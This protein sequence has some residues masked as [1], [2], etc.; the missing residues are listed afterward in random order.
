MQQYLAAL[1]RRRWL[2][3][4]SALLS[5]G[6]AFGLSQLQTPIYTSTA[7]VLV[8]SA[9]IST[10]QGDEAPNM[11]TESR[12]AKSD[13]VA[14]IVKRNLGL[15]LDP[16][17][18]LSHLSISVPVN[19]EVMDFAYSDPSPRIARQRTQAFAGAY[20]AFR[21]S[22]LLGALNAL[23]E[24]IQA[25]INSLNAQLVVIQNEL[26]G[27]VT[28]ARRAELQTEAAAITS[29]IT[30][31]EQ[32]LSDLTP[33][34]GL[35]V[36]TVVT[37]ADLPRSPSSP[38]FILNL[39]L[40]AFVGLA[41]GVGL[42]TIRERLDTR[43][44]SSE[45]LARAAGAPV[46]AEIPSFPRRLRQGSDLVMLAEPASIE[47]ESFRLLATSISATVARLSLRTL[48]VSSPSNS[49]GKTTTVANLA[50][51][52]AQTGRKV[53]LISA[54]LR[55]PRLDEIFL[56][57][58]DFF[59]DRESPSTTHILSQSESGPFP[60]G[61]HGL[62]LVSTFRVSRRPGTNQLDAEGMTYLLKML[63]RDT[64]IVLI[65]SAPLLVAA[66][67]TVLAGLTDGVVLVADAQST[68][69]GAMVKAR[70]QLNLI[71]SDVVGAV[72]SNAPRSGARY[73]GYYGA[74]D[75]AARAETS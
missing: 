72:L 33:P 20:L 38:N 71:G 66:D 46:L 61:I 42:A 13:T 6:A 60:T 9:S 12:L 68:T 34:E 32:R 2:V 17:V 23:A 8:K 39:I 15:G 31:L 35:Q 65:D 10:T 45:A 3:V 50:V 53:A 1:S 30:V 28:P 11:D 57:L 27:T 70:H 52:L 21:H 62:T 48:L 16:D 37:P 14:R 44:A 69:R 47:A 51:A 58:D 74:D 19:T 4:A 67:S 36:G 54:D 22:Q 7:Q 24:P 75:V 40:G 56:T 29:R 63:Q 59:V 18:L 73:Y 43:L 64:E 5:I 25:Q 49:E 26:A 55:R 41:I